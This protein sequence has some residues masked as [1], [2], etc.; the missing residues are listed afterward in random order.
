M[1]VYR[2]TLPGN[3]YALERQINRNAAAPLGPVSLLPGE[4]HVRMN[5]GSVD[6]GFLDFNGQQIRYRGALRSLTELNES[7]ANS[8]EAHT[9]LLSEHVGR[10]NGHDADVTR[11]DAKDAVQD[12]SLSRKA[13][14]S[15]V[16]QVRDDANARM[17]GIDGSLASHNTRINT[18]QS[19]ADNANSRAST[20]EGNIASHNTRINTAQSAANTAQS[21]ADSAYSRAGT[22]ISNAATA[23]SRADAAYSLAATKAADSRVDSEVARL[24]AAIRKVAQNTG[25]PDPFL[26]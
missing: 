13:W 20:L 6:T 18:A 3:Q 10:L 8:I 19:G 21:R 25:T 26:M 24:V 12:D 22:G 7:F 4:G 1:P 16:V 2:P 9:S 17:T 11:I 14:T 23:Q 5:D 15:Y